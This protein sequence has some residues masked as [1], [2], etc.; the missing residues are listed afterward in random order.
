VP[1]G[2]GAI[3][4]GGGQ[5]GLAVTYHLQ[6]LGVEHLV[7]ER[8]RIGESWRTQRWDS[9]TMNTPNWMNG[10]PGADYDGGDPEGFMGRDEWVD[11]LERYVTRFGLPV[12]TGVGVT[13]L[14][15]ADGDGF[16]VRTDAP[17][18]E[19]IA[20]RAVVV[21]SGPLQAPKAPAAAKGLHPAIPGIHAADYR[22]AAALPPGAVLVVGSAQSGCQIAED[23][24][25]AG[26]RVYLSAG[27]TGRVPRRYRGRDILEWW[28]DTGILDQRPET[29]ED[30]SARFAPQPQISGIGPR[31]HSLSLQHLA[32]RGVTLLGRW[33]GTEGGRLTF[34]DT[35]GEAVRFADE[36]SAATKKG[37]D[38]Y[39]AAHGL[40]AP[41]PEDDPGDRPHPDPA[42][43]H[44]PATLDVRREGI[45]SVVWCIGFTADYSWIDL[46][47]CDENGAPI[48]HGG[49]SPVPGLYFTG[50][51]W[52]SRRK[53]ALIYGA[54]EDAGR[55]AG[56]V[57]EHLRPAGR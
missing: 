34:T 45:G 52:M 16:A 48:H 23:L 11:R 21:A 12:R 38:D 30:P 43:L 37:I 29:L 41:A 6:R 19:T 50:L 4:V 36:R 14:A 22:D 46:P 10:L 56:H 39:I 20:A 31:G 24:L 40:E 28:R 1:D 44:S 42:S 8:G 57:A 15:A 2:L 33:Q 47:A 54:A 32:G 3:V 7:L 25:D 51:P 55:I 5:A 49:V 9:F 27:R 17:H 13:G 53:S 18:L 26:R 35:V